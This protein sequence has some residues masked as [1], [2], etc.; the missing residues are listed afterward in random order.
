MT[1]T[2]T[3][4]E[5]TTPIETTPVD[6]GAENEKRTGPAD[7]DVTVSFVAGEGIVVRGTS[8]AMAAAIKPVMQRHS[9]RWSNGLGAWFRPQSRSWSASDGRA[10]TVH[11]I[12][13]DLTA[14]GIA[15]QGVQSFD[16][17]DAAERE[18][19]RRERSAARAERLSA[20]ASKHAGEAHAKH[21][22]AEQIGERF[23]M[24]QPILVGHHSEKRARRDQE[25]MHDA[26]R[27]SI[28]AHDQ[29]EHYVRAAAAAERNTAGKTPAQ[30]ARKIHELEAE[31]CSVQRTLDQANSERM[32]LR[33]VEIDGDLAY[34]REELA[35]TG[36][37][38]ET[39]RA[40]YKAGDIVLQ[41]GRAAIV[42]RVGPKNATVVWLRS[43]E[44][45]DQ[46]GKLLASIRPLTEEQQAALRAQYAG[47]LEKIA[48][49]DAEKKAKPE[50]WHWKGKRTTPGGFKITDRR[51]NG[52]YFA[53]PTKPERE[54]SIH[55]QR[56]GDQRFYVEVRDRRTDAFRI[57]RTTQRLGSFDTLA[58]AVGAAERHTAHEG[59]LGAE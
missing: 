29:A 48:A 13:S 25:R 49:R 55:H 42:R 7:A 2:T 9:L 38:E 10:S 21:A 56:F 32:R 34:W 4:T 14:A 28:V 18:A 11:A 35:K 58:E 46:P 39:D 52:F 12:A 15:A 53:H 50:G 20:K 17:R 51:D 57:N 31:A 44:L 22:R 24:G 3:T 19:T 26:M 8:R 6:A 45:G 33:A 54:Y 59:P 1:E 5:P 23:Y 41:D 43:P 30:M 16:I 27:A 47:A 40:T 37:V 36:Y